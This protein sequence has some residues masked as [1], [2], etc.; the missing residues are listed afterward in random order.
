MKSVL[1]LLLTFLLFA[2]VYLSSQ[3]TLTLPRI[4]LDH[5]I[6]VEYSVEVKDF[7]DISKMELVVLYDGN[8]ISTP[9]QL[10]FYPNNNFGASWEK[11]V[12]TDSIIIT[13]TT[14]AGNGLTL[15]DGENLYIGD[16]FLIEEVCN[17]ASAMKISNST[18]VYRNIGDEEVEIGYIPQEGFYAVKCPDSRIPSFSQELNICGGFKFENYNITGN[19][20]DVFQTQDGQDSIR[21]LK[22]D[23]NP[24]TSITCL[25]NDTITIPTGFTHIALSRPF[26]NRMDQS[27]IPV[28][29][30]GT[31]SFA[32]ETVQTGVPQSRNVFGLGSTHFLHTFRNPTIEES[33]AYTV[34]VKEGFVTEQLPSFSMSDAAVTEGASFCIDVTTKNFQEAFAFTSFI[35]WDSTAFEF[36]EAKIPPIYDN[37]PPLYNFSTPNLVILSWLTADIFN[38]QSFPDNTVLYSLCFNAKKTGQFSIN[39]FSPS[40][41]DLSINEIVIKKENGSG[42][43]SEMWLKSATVDVTEGPACNVITT[44]EAVQICQG[45]NYILNNQ[46]Y[47]QTGNY[48]T[49]FI[50][51]DGCDSIVQLALEVLPVPTAITDTFNT[52]ENEVFTFNLS[53]NDIIPADLNWQ[54]AIISS[55]HIGQLTDLGNGQFS[56]EPRFAYTGTTSFDYQIC[57]EICLPEGCTT[58]EVVLNIQGKS[59][60]VGTNPTPLPAPSI[61]QTS[62]IQNPTV[63]EGELIIF[64]IYG[65]Q[66]E[67]RYFFNDARQQ[68]WNLQQN[69]LSAGIYFYVKRAKGNKK[70]I[71]SGKIIAI[72]R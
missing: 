72:G 6:G 20:V 24:F 10:F 66:I 12:Y 23:V 43:I 3:P 44:M 40:N 45:E 32:V 29:Q 34:H 26:T 1:S 35:N 19:Y 42:G 25:P 71:E 41:R 22:L 64:N 28:V 65:Q 36:I 33:C 11:V 60:G 53:Q 8:T 18:K 56:Y 30:S 4:E 15:P 46:A 51:T 49:T 9:N 61:A 21:T 62:K 52:K 68:L 5:I 39:F 13:M 2:P 50:T 14:P 63:Q 47:N 7:T 27:T 31:C 55:P 59:L 37:S 17:Q 54:A 57:N 67:N 16:F 58:T 70:I 48:E 38:G 69:E